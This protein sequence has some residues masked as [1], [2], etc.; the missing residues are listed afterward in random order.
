MAANRRLQLSAMLKHSWAGLAAA[1][2]NLAL[3][4]SLGAVGA[5]VALER[6][7][8]PVDQLAQTRLAQPLQIYSHD[9]QRIAEFGDQRRIPLDG[10]ALP[11]HLVQAILAAEDAS[12]FDHPGFD[13]RSLLRA[14]WQLLRTGEPNQG[15]STITMQVARNFFLS[16]EKTFLRKALEILL[17]IRIEQNLSKDQ[18]LGLYVNKIFLGNRAYGFGAAALI[19][20]GRP[21]DSLT[22]SQVAMLAG[23][24]KAPSRDNPLVNPR[25]AVER[26][27]Y[28]LGRMYVLGYLDADDYR[29]ALAQPDAAGHYGFTPEVEADYVAEMARAWMLERYGESAYENGYRVI[30]TIDSGQQRAANRALQAG[31]LAYDRRHGFRGP[32]TKI[33]A[34]A[35]ADPAQMQARLRALP[36]AGALRPAVRLPNGKYALGT[37][38]VT[39]VDGGTDRFGVNWQASSGDV[40]YLAHSPDGWKLAQPPA[41]E[42]AFVALQPDSGAITALVGGYDFNRSHFNRAVQAQRQPGSTFK[43]FIYAAALATGYTAA[44]IVN[45]APVAFPADTPDGYW[46]PENYTGRFYGPTRLREAL[47]QSRNLVSVRLL[48]A[49][50]V[51]FARRYILRFGFA[52]E[53]LPPNLSLAL[54]T[55]SV[56]PLEL[57]AAYAVIANGGYRVNPYIVEQVLDS[58]GAVLWQAPRVVL[59]EADCETEPALADLVTQAP[60]ALPATDAYILNS[61]LRDVIDHGTAVRAKSLGRP[62][63]AGKTGTTNDEHDAWFAGFNKALLAIAWV[64]F[65]QPRSLGRGET[66]A[67]TALPIW[68]NFTSAVLPDL[69]VSSPP[70]PNGLVSLR[71]DRHSGQRT[72][73]SGPDTLFEWFTADRLPPALSFQPEPPAAPSGTP[74]SVLF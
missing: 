48:N 4:I 1:I 59:C 29:L 69:P 20:Y 62:D 36:G 5:Y 32:V 17:A 50:G 2:P 61:M 44:S 12:F 55:A 38:Y 34:S 47:A 58:Q 45:D 74:E 13:T 8:P 60:R 10:D 52:A 64:G 3:L 57:A 22:V 43:P 46:R 37:Q 66:G 27:D 31:L 16:Q 15:G 14:A 24:P 26:R 6:E 68:M 19:Y 54:G 42:G 41:V 18:I 56:T 33:P 53:R 67:R 28:V 30:T 70:I 49:V 7:L 9:G 72:T 71:V 40:V 11:K 51:D 23:L 35:L 39:L 25:R 73:S 21:V 65:D 63:L